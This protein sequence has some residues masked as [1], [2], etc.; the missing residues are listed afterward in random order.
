MRILMVGALSIPYIRENWV[1]P[2]REL[3]DADYVDA[4]LLL[5][6]YKKQFAEKYLYRILTTGCYDYLFFYN[7]AIRPEFSA[8]FFEHVKNAEVK[9][10]TFYSDD[11]PERWYQA[12]LPF[13]KRYDLIA[14]HSLRGFEHRLNAGSAVNVMYLPWGYNPKYFQKTSC[15]DKIYDVVCFA[16]AKDN[17][18]LYF[19]EGQHR[20]QLLVELY[21]YCLTY[22]YSFKLYGSGWENHP[23]LK[24]C[25]GGFV[26]LTEM[27]QIYNQ[28]KIVFNPGY[29]ADFDQVASQTKLRHF[30][31]PGCGAFQLTNENEELGQL[32]KEDKSIVFFR[33][34]EDMKEKI[35]YYLVHDAE[36]EAIAQAGY[37]QALQNHTMQHRIK[38]LFS[39]AQLRW[40][41]QSAEKAKRLRILP[42]V[43]KD[44]QD[45]INQVAALNVAEVSQTYDYAHLLC[46]R[47]SAR[48]EYSLLKQADF[49]SDQWIGLKS[50]VQT[51]W[52]HRD[53]MQRTKQ[54]VVGTVLGE[55]VNKTSYFDYL[56]DFLRQETFLL[57]DSQEIVL[58]SHY[59]IPIHQISEAMN[60][61][62]ENKW[63]DFENIPK[64]H[65]QLIINDWTLPDSIC[66]PKYCCVPY[67]LRLRE[68]FAKLNLKQERIAFYG[69]RGA[70][71]DHVLEVVKEENE[72]QVVGIIDRDLAGS[73]V[74]GLPVYAFDDI[75]SL[76]IT[77]L[78]ITAE[79]SGPG[80]YSAV[81]KYE[82]RMTIVPLY[83]L[84]DAVWDVLLN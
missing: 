77:L 62:I 80:I 82:G 54:N 29:S 65:S 74:G 45:L 36:R 41:V 19:Q 48:S 59:L 46:G 31:V 17:P 61:F 75:E 13:D 81:K 35:A 69:G 84:N 9:V 39:E 32:F 12:N 50:Y 40:P 53:A 71:I 4:T 66:P 33:Q 24:D 2:L 58:L 76:N 23:V 20:K 57:E 37:E 5:G 68:L 15:Q 52:L 28:A 43:A 10:I 51:T 1:E 30:E 34:A 21:E 67:Q 78:I 49:L 6:T 14:T 70:M 3:Y 63:S 22:G 55:V 25:A 42:V 44:K 72:L 26:S 27:V 7:D 73:Q 56:W 83:D 16:A 64:Y 47:I 38:T 11:E 79:I 8:E 60:I 18:I